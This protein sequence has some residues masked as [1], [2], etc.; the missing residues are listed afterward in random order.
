[1]DGLGET[2]MSPTGKT[3][4]VRPVAPKAFTLIELILVMAMLV[5][6]MSVLAPSLGNFFRGRSVDGEVRRL[7]SL[8]RYGRE[9][10]ISE[11]T[12]MILWID[13]QQ[14]AYGLTEDST[15]AAQD[16][17]AVAYPL[18]RDVLV[19][20]DASRVNAAP[21]PVSLPL[22]SGY[23]PGRAAYAIRF[24]PDG[25]IAD[26]SPIQIRIREQNPPS[27]SR[28]SRAGTLWLAPSASRLT[29][30][31]HTNFTGAVRF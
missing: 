21:L 5:V 15:Y 29:Y 30:D 13:P 23:R 9:R 11:G 25:F 19:E 20:V 8:I 18:S 1:M 26:S 17:R 31:L 7:S 12:P 14:R 27:G 28:N 24:Q 16:A 4:N 10:A 22:V 3:R 2:T 6:L